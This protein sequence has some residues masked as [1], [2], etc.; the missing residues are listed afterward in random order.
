MYIHVSSFRSREVP[1]SWSINNTTNYHVSLA[2]M[3]WGYFRDT[4]AVTSPNPSTEY[5]TPATPSPSPPHRRQQRTD[6]C[7]SGW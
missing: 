4:H 2:V 1:T 3:L 5:S 7:G 6:R